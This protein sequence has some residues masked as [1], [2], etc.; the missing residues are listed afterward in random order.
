MTSVK[1]VME[2]LVENRAPNL[3]EKALSKIFDQLIWCLKDNGSE[4]E[5]VRKEWLSGDDL[6]RIKIALY[7]SDTFPYDSKKE[8]I[9]HFEK[10]V[11][12]W[13]ELKRD[14]DDIIKDWENQFE[15]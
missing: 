13:P 14:C 7:M 11:E 1:Q 15:E 4:I 5:T 2:F 3:A 9:K 6:V 12:R 10:I 8:L